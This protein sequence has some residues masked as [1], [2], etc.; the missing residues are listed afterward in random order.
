MSRLMKRVVARCKRGRPRSDQ[1]V[2]RFQTD[3][4]AEGDLVTVGGYQTFT[5]TAAAI[6]HKSAKWFYMELDRCSAPWAFARREPFRAI[7]SQEL[8]GTMLGLILRVNEAGG[9]DEYFACGLS[10]GGIM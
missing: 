1:V 7:A 5:A 9:S 2:E 10:V 4:K 8:L 6:P 3:A